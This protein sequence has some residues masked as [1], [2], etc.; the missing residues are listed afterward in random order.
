MKWQKKVVGLILIMFGVAFTMCVLFFF[1]HLRREASASSA[2]GYLTQLQYRI[3]YYYDHY[4]IF[5]EYLSED[6]ETVTWSWR[7]VFPDADKQFGRWGDDKIQYDYAWNSEKNA[8]A[9]ENLTKFHRRHFS[10]KDSDQEKGLSNIVAVKG[11]GISSLDL[12]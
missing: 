2:I 5:P 1:T 8:E 11:K 7:V 10:S 12:S 6:K 3:V 4:K 9:L